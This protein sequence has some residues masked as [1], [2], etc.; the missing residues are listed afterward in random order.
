M[1]GESRA[2]IIARGARQRGAPR[3]ALH[4]TTDAH[5]LW[6][7]NAAL[8]RLKRLLAIQQSGTRTASTV[9][10]LT[11]VEYQIEKLLNDAQNVLIDQA[12]AEEKSTCDG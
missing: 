5:F 1:A 3:E 10:E 11:H 7:I 8:H 12:L 6:R 9:Q 4:H 2:L